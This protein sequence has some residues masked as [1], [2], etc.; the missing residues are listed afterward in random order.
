MENFVS[1]ETLRGVQA[2][3]LS[4]QNSLHERSPRRES[5]DTAQAAGKTR[6]QKEDSNPGGRVLPAVR[7]LPASERPSHRRL[8]V[9][10]GDS[11]LQVR[12]GVLEEAASSS[13]REASS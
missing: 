1:D 10:C 11:A 2:N 13:S 6:L 8:R 7:P 12:L 5:L 4:A 9:A 3:L